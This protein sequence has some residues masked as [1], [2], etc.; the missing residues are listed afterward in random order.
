ME[1]FYLVLSYFQLV[2]V[3]ERISGCPFFKTRWTYP[4]E[5]KDNIY[6][7]KPIVIFNFNFLFKLE[8]VNLK[9]SCCS[10]LAKNV[11]TL[12]D[13]EYSLSL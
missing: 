11:G 4:Q 12:G 6:P 10:I 13:S 9:V 7:E 8:Y 2:S 5:K 3:R 1:S